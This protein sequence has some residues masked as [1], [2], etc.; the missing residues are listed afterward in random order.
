MSTSFV[1]F[2]AHPSLERLQAAFI[3]QKFDSRVGSRAVQLGNKAG[4]CC[5]A[6]VIAECKRESGDALQALQQGQIQ[7]V[8]VICAS[9]MIGCE[10]V[11]R[12][13]IVDVELQ[14]VEHGHL[15][16]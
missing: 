16:L 12:D 14:Y 11:H 13:G 7:A 15:V 6:G 10:G 3:F 4:S 2:P 8:G 1:D 5:T 9:A